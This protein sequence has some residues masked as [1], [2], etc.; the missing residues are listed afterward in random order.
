MATRILILALILELAFFV[1][2]MHE[3]VQISLEKAIIEIPMIVLLLY[4]YYKAV[5]LDEKVLA[6]CVLLQLSTHMSWT[7]TESQKYH[8][9]WF[10]DYSAFIIGAF[11]MCFA[12][13]LAHKDDAGLLPWLSL[14]AGAA[15]YNYHVRTRPEFKGSVL[16]LTIVVFAVIQQFFTTR[17]FVR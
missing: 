16:A 3:K 7:L 17:A 14:S 4:M 8:D 10:V 11:E 12:V 13:R 15:S 1:L 6:F 5:A 9:H 2:V